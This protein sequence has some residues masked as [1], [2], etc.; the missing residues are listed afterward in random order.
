MPFI[1]DE[2]FLLQSDTARQ[3]YRRYAAQQPVHDFHSH[4]S[5]AD[6]VADRQFN[7]LDEPGSKAIITSGAPC[8]PME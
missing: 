4:M 2:G 1:N 8:A 7:D 5:P 6:L 3:L